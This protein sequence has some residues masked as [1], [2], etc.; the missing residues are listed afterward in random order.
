MTDFELATLRRRIKVF[1]KTL[2][3]AWCIHLAHAVYVLTQ[4]LVRRDLIAYVLIANVFLSLLWLPVFY[5][6]LKSESGGTLVGC[7]I[8]LNKETNYMDCM[9][10]V[11]VCALSIYFHFVLLLIFQLLKYKV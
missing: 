8:S 9:G 3:Y 2:P 10:C 5:R 4:D 11:V 1:L 7:Y 6:F